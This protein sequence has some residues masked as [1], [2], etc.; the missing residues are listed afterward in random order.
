MRTRR[1]MAGMS[2]VELMI[3]IML[4]LMVLAGLASVFASSSRS[5]S[6]LE[7]ASRQ[8]ENG[9]YAIEILSDDLRSAGF[10]GE[11]DLSP[12]A[13][14]GALPD[15]CSTDPAVWGQSLRVA[16][17]GY[18]NGASAPACIPADVQP[19]SDVLVVRHVA[20]CEAGAAGCPAA[21]NGM[22]Y[23]QAAKCGTQVASAATEYEVGIRG[24]AAF[25]RQLKDCAAAAG[26]R[27]YIVD[28]YYLSTNNGQGAAIP[29]LKRLELDP[30]AASSFANAGGFDQVPIAEG[31]ERMNLEYGIDTDND[32][33][34]D[35][36]TADPANYAPAGCGSC[37][38]VNN[39]ANVVAVRINL[40]ARSTEASPGFTDAKTY[41]LGL[42]AAGAPITYTPNDAYHRHAYSTL[43]RVVN[44][45]QR[46][47]TP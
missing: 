30:L 36:F 9:R 32:G 15:P 11:L 8:I 31:I 28:I 6:E 13:V 35:A 39:W 2:I 4:G 19:A 27:R 3:A 40:L 16:V 45:S 7:R 33:Q 17:Q 24:T 12:F 5:R 25:S 38:A 23:F 47:E 46:R 37:N 43:V 44:V 20:G 41:T 34:P 26:L 10:Y 18:D 42:D 1:S 14:P 29:T 21:V 22:P